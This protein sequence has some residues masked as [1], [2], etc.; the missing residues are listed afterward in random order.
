MSEQPSPGAET[1]AGDSTLTPA[2][3]VSPRNA[4]R[5][6]LWA[7]IILIILG[8]AGWWFGYR[9][10]QNSNPTR[11]AKTRAAVPVIA[12]KARL[13]NVPIHLTGLGS[14]EALNT[15]TVR[16]RVDGELIKVF[17]KEGQLVHAGDRLVEIDPRPYQVQLDQ[18]KAQLAKDQ[19]LLANAQLDLQRDELAGEAIS[20]QQLDTQKATVAQ[21]Q[22]ALK[23]DQAQ[24]ESAQL[25]LTYCHITAPITGRIGLRLVDQGNIVHASD[26]NGLAVITEIQP[27]AV[28]FSLPQRYIPQ[29]MRRMRAGG[30]VEVDAYQ[31]QVKLATGKVLA[32]DNQVDLASGTIH[33]KAIFP[34]KNFALFPNQYVDASLLVD[35]EKNVV[36]VP[37]VAVQLGP[38]S[39]FVYVVKKDNTVEVRDIKEG[40]QENQLAVIESGLKPGETVVTE[41]VDKLQAGTKVV[42]RLAS[43]APTTRPGATATTRPA[44]KK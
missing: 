23:I 5:G 13:A 8:I 20:Q 27:I 2:P 42:V 40:A 4:G 24:I 38:D 44:G 6:C 43:A 1:P 28:N 26:P 29:V 7:I 12:V 33:I 30:D 36:V 18:A 10:K 41:G 15:V 3:P 19:S 11:G 14:V 21:D 16:T 22:A 39:S 17:Y 32:V 37:V 25:N 9:G 35:V 31:N 34:N